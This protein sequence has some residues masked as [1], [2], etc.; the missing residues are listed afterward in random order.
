M[1]K[2]SNL[3]LHPHYLARH[4]SSIVTALTY[5][6]RT[7]RL[8]T[9]HPRFFYMPATNGAQ[10]SISVSLYTA[11]MRSLTGDCAAVLAS[12]QAIK[13]RSLREAHDILHAAYASACGRSIGDGVSLTSMPSQTLFNACKYVRDQI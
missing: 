7:S 3:K 12:N 1:F 8:T 6:R 5:L 10:A 9:W 2:P 13:M 11:K 4:F